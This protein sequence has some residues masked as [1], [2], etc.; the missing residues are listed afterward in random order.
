MEFD[1]IMRVQ[2]DNEQDLLFKQIQI[3]IHDGT[4]TQDD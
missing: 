2:G 3:R 4:S 1:E